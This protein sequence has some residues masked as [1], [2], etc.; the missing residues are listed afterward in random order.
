MTS[1]IGIDLG[2]TNSLLAYTQREGEIQVAPLGDG[3]GLLPS[4]VYIEKGG[5]VVVGKGARLLSTRD[6]SGFFEHWKRDMGDR[7]WERKREGL[8]LTPLLLS[9]FVLKRL[10][11]DAAIGPVEEAVITVPAWF[12]DLERGATLDAAKIAGIARARALNEPTAAAL[13][14]GLDPESR[15]EGLR[16]ALVYDLGGGTFDVTVVEIEHGK[17]RVLATAGERK[18][19]GKD[20][21]DELVNLVSERVYERVS[22]D[23]REDERLMTVLRVDCE[24]AKIA[25]SSATRAVVKVALA[26]ETQEVLVTR[27]QLEQRTRGL[28]EQTETHVALVLEKA[29]L[30]W[31]D[32]DVVL[33]VGGSTRMPMILT[34]LRRI[35]NKEPMALLNPEEAVA[36]G[37]CTYAA[38]LARGGHVAVEGALGVR[39]DAEPSPP[40]S[41]TG[42]VTVAAEEEELPLLPGERRVPEVQ[43]VVSHGLGVLVVTPRG[44]KNVVLIP[45]QTPVPVRKARPFFTIKDGQRAVRVTVTEGDGDDPEGCTVLGELVV[46]GLPGERPK[47]QAIDVSYEYDEDGRVR[48][49]AVDVATGKAARCTI[50]RVGA[51]AKAQIDALRAELDER[52]DE[53]EGKA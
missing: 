30:A 1:S 48:V 47:G 24:K 7:H 23:P 9:S 12:G 34:A 10:V 38:L 53:A 4:C 45:E 42:E 14:Y 26:D 5:G 25:L 28:V 52:F 35:S 37:A 29:R 32:I 15:T 27:D 43:D 16:R 33:P 19:G 41:D 31:D 17:V 50:E 39:E 21:D 18:L 46:D 13:A 40:S 22:F 20:W 11:K 6:P 2:T 36:R 49:S 51:L 44:M 3:S 8:V